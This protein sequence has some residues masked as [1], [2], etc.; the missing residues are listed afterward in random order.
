MSYAMG[1]KMNSYKKALAS[2]AVP[3]YNAGRLFGRNCESL[4]SPASML[5]LTEQRHT[6]RKVAACPRNGRNR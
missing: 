5:F 6:H 4:N 2:H 1:K 3:D